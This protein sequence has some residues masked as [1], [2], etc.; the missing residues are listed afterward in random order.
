MGLIE[1][2]DSDEGEVT[3]LVFSKKKVSFKLGGLQSYFFGNKVNNV[4]LE[5]GNYVELKYF[6]MEDE[7]VGFE[8][9]IKSMD[10]FLENGGYILYSIDL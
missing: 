1:K 10:V 8:R 2:I 3:N 5:N 6:P 9:K 7:Q 4:K